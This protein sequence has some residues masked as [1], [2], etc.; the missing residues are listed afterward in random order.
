MVSLCYRI[1]RSRMQWFLFTCLHCSLMMHIILLVHQNVKELCSC[2]LTSTYLLISYML[3]PTP[4]AEARWKIT[5]T[6]PTL[7]L[8]P[9]HQHVSEYVRCIWI[10]IVRFSLHGLKA[11]AVKN[12]DLASPLTHPRDANEL[13]PSHPYLNLSKLRRFFSSFFTL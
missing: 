1:N 10:E 11:Q 12:N 7:S 6:L 5:S 2:L 9:P 3:C 4:T 13:R 8:T